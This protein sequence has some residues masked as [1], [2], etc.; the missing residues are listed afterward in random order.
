MIKLSDHFNYRRLLRFTL[1]SIIM[2]IV[3]SVYGVVDGIFVSN[4]AGKIPFAAINLIMPF[5]LICG[6]LGFMAGTGGSAL[7]AR[8]LGQGDPTKAN[9]IFSL[10]VYVSIIAGIVLS[11]ISVA[12]L[13]DIAI[14]LGAEGEMLTDCVTYGRIILPALSA[15]I[16]QNVFQAFL[17]T[18]ERPSLGLAITI[19]A[20]V[21]NIVLD[22]I[23]IVPFD[24]GLKG[25]ALATAISQC[26]GGIIPLLYF[27]FPNKSL[28]QLTRA[29]FDG[30]A[31]VKTCT[32]GSSELIANISMS[33]VSMMYNYQLI[34]Y[35]GADGVAAYGVIMYAA[36]IFIAVF[37]GFSIGSAPIVS[38]NY[39]AEN[40]NELRNVFRRS[41][42]ILA[43]IAIVLT[44]AAIALAGPL[45]SI[46][47]GYDQQLFLLTRKAFMIYS[48]SFILV[49]INLYTS[50]FFT[51]L[52]NGLI[53]AIVSFSRTLI[54]EV[55]AV[56]LIPYILG[57][58][59]I[60]IS[61]SV[62]ESLAIVMSIIFL[63]ANK[64]LYHY[65]Q[66]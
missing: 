31:I 30:N 61:I 8:T 37:L 41:L 7:V 59:G 49:W 1:P 60:W 24:M 21:T 45:A 15:Y 52:N 51:A 23:F 33:I 11:A 10:L 4:F 16:L 18:A 27:A 38:Y 12:Y 13:E 57:I 19:I 14:M 17:I 47:V 26:L 53:S 56:L 32:N 43:T 39:G 25:A 62:A 55:G 28:L 34:R 40:Y 36:Y 3:T 2:M 5:L 44:I 42:I 35:I 50:A 48:M 66:H 58:D 63:A 20:G 29:R 46:F 9:R 22:Y 54:F 64:K 65:W 6:S